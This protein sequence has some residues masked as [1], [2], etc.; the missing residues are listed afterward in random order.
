MLQEG[1]T[2]GRAVVD[3]AGKPISL[4]CQYGVSAELLASSSFVCCSD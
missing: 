4:S 2:E 3:G 1:G